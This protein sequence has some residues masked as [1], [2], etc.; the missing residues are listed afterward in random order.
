[1]GQLLQ[2]RQLQKVIR[3]VDGVDTAEITDEA[4]E[5]VEKLEAIA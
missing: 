5:R 4:N 3:A 2:G 1:M